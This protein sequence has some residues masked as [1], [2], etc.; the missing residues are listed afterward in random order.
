[1]VNSPS[2]SGQAAL[3]VPTLAAQRLRLLAA[4]GFGQRP[5]LSEE[6]LSGRDGF[7]TLP[8]GKAT[9]KDFWS[10]AVAYDLPVLTQSWGAVV[11]SSFYEHGWYRSAAAG[12]HDFYGPGAG[13]RV[14]LRKLAIPALGVDAAYNLQSDQT[15]FSIAVGMQM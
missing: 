11:I 1:M 13:F 12:E 2:I 8:F 4:G 15:V 7:R 9:A 6:P 10:T 14:Y 5:L 3:N